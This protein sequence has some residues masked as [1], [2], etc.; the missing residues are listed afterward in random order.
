MIHASAAHLRITPQ[1]YFPDCKLP[2][3]NCRLYKIDWWRRLLPP[4]KRNRELTTLSL[5]PERGHRWKRG[6]E[7]PGNSPA[8]PPTPEG[9]SQNGTTTVPTQRKS[10]KPPTI[11]EPPSPAAT[12]ER[13]RDR[14]T[15]N[16]TENSR[17]YP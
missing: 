3:A 17:T 6:G 2:S 7:A 14:G 11:N 1:P 4:R 15:V 16:A 12:K 5:T 13:S 10:Q 9:R 8:I